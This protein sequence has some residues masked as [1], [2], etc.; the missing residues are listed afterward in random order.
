MKY[1]LAL[2]DGLTGTFADPGRANSVLARCAEVGHLISPATIVSALPPGIEISVSSVLVDVPLETYEPPGSSKRA[3]SKVALDRIAGAA[4][5]SWDASRSGVVDR[6]ENRCVF[7]VSGS[8]LLL[9]GREREIAG[10]REIDVRDGSATYDAMIETSIAKARRGGSRDPERE[11]REAAL[12]QIREI[13]KH[14]LSHTETKAALRAIRRGFS[15]RAT[16]SVEELARPFLVVRPVF[17][18]R[19]EDPELRRLFGQA[20]VDRFMG[21]RERLYGPPARFAKPIAVDVRTERERADDVSG[22]DDDDSAPGAPFAPDAN[23]PRETSPGAAPRPQ[24]SQPSGPVP[25]AGQA[26][27]TPARGTSPSEA[28]RSLAR[29]ETSFRTRLPGKGRPADRP[30][31]DQAETSQLEWWASTLTENLDGGKT[32]D[33]YRAADEDTLEAI[34]AELE[35][36]SGGGELRAMGAQLPL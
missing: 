29:P 1:D 19:T 7:T 8:V 18:G 22:A 24:S 30:T 36:R 26:G 3:L 12:N 11:G 32:P 28:E 20:V 9:D 34:E 6:E 13:R 35:W 16:Y 21:A 14:L 2:L 4:G 17:T 23:V 27:S 15:I 10:T 25:T 5:V 33:R 31:L